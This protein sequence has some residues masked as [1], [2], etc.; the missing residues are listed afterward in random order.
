MPPEISFNQVFAWREMLA[1]EED[2]SPLALEE[3]ARLSASDVER[4]RKPVKRG[5]IER[6]TRS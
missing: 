5:A 6:C 1:S 2:L 4:L 3:I